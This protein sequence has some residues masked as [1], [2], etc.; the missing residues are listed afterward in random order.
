MISL[1]ILA[2]ICIVSVTSSPNVML[3]PTVT[4]PLT[5]RFPVMLT[6]SSKLIVPAE[7][8][9]F[10]S[11]LVLEIVFPLILIA[12]ASTFVPSIIVV[13]VPSV[14]FIPWVVVGIK[15]QRL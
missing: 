12:P 1:S 15:I 6:S 9:M 11:P 13:F 10:M 3:P 8:F 5:S 7:L 14:K 4:F 2:L